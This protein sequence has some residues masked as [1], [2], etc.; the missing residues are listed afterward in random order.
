MA[1]CVD[2][3]ETEY[4]KKVGE[5]EIVP[6]QGVSLTRAFNGKNLRRKKPIYWEHE[7]NRAMRDGKWKL[8]AKGSTGPWELYDIEA[9]RT[10]LNNLAEKHPKRLKR[11][12]DDWEAWAVAALAKPW[13]WKNK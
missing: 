12:V 4:P 5:V 10:E 13:P 7:G 9:D 2:L 6:L 11:M 1:T 8:V 3:A